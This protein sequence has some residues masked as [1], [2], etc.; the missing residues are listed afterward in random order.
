MESTT[1]E[2][3]VIGAG[4]GGLATLAALCDAGLNPILWIDRTFEGGRL[5]TVYR[6]ISSSVSF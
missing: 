5:N 6:E 1:Y 3:I 4:P 2:A